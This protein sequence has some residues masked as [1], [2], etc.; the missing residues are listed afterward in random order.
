MGCVG[1]A[2]ASVPLQ[3]LV[4]TPSHHCSG[5]YAESVPL[6]PP[7]PQHMCCVHVHAHTC[8]HTRTRTHAHT[9]TYTST[10]AAERIKANQEAYPDAAKRTVEKA[11]VR[12]VAGK[13][14]PQLAEMNAAARKPLKACNSACGNGT[15]SAPWLP[16]S[17]TPHTSLPPSGHG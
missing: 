6:I 2:G 5:A 13:R 8:T 4:H 7:S 15:P 3:P 1:G 9:H 12:E 10:Q 11:E 16:R 17:A 14:L